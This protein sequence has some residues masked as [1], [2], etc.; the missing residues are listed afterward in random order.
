M[1]IYIRKDLEK[2]VLNFKK[3]K[4]EKEENLKK[5]GIEYNKPDKTNQ[6]MEDQQLLRRLKDLENQ[7]KVKDEELEK[8]KK[9]KNEE[10]EKYKKE[11]KK[12]KEEKEKIKE[13]FQKSK[14]LKVEELE[15]Y[16]K[17]LKEKKQKIEFRDVENKTTIFY[18]SYDKNESL[19][20]IFDEFEIKNVV[21]IFACTSFTCNRVSLRSTIQ[22]ISSSNE[23]IVVNYVTGSK[24][25][26]R[27]MV[28]IV[29]DGNASFVKLRLN[30]TFKNWIKT[31][32][33]YNFLSKNCVIYFVNKDKNVVDVT[34]EKIT[35]KKINDYWKG[36]LLVVDK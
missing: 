15:K 34:N 29:I 14:N 18:R 30:V 10:A 25:S 13:E 21:S 1:L 19:Q 2:E 9:A 35:N 23:K 4:E 7:L 20:S 28:W 26:I 33:E 27:D 5:V 32:P 12:E 16:K 31:L 22:E 3:E 36:Y 24:D 11:L 17:E 6:V 8:Y